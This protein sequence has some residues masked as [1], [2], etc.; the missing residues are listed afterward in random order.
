MHLKFF[1]VLALMHQHLT[2]LSVL[3][4]LR[5]WKYSIEGL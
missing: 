4:V 3:R 1:H 5:Q 2:M